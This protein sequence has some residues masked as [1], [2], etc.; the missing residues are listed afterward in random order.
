MSRYISNAIKHTESMKK[1]I[2][3]SKNIPGFE[4]LD[5]STKLSQSYFNL[6]ALHFKNKKFSEYRRY[7]SNSYKKLQGKQK[8]FLYS[9]SVTPI[10]YLVIMAAIK[11]RK[12]F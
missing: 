11:L 10:L 3:E 12:R 4:S 5:C 8:I 2:D 1:I 9:E 7:I 6:A